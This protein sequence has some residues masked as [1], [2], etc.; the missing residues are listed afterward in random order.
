VTTLSDV[1]A[2]HEWLPAREASE[3]ERCSCG[4]ICRRQGE[5][6]EHRERVT[7]AFLAADAAPI[8]YWVGNKGAATG[9]NVPKPLPPTANPRLFDNV[10]GREPPPLPQHPDN[11]HEHW[12][13]CARC[14]VDNGLNDLLVEL[15]E[16]GVRTKEDLLAYLDH[17]KEQWDDSLLSVQ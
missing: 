13:A 5:W 7:R 1:Y 11:G 16:R 17:L 6:A 4:L 2:A 14:G 8:H 9:G 15:D 3:V 12:Y 10:E